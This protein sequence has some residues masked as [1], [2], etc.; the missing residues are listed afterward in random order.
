MH[1]A[2]IVASNIA[3]EDQMKDIDFT[4]ARIR[5]RWQAGFSDTQRMLALAPWTQ[6]VDPI[7]GIF[8][9]DAL[10]GAVTPLAQGS[11]GFEGKSK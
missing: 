11:D 3:N 10:P 9:H 1:I 2:R 5:A 7:E 4:P 8:I 6:P